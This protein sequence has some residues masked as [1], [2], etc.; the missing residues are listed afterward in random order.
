MERDDQISGLIDLGSVSQDTQGGEGKYWEG[1]AE[2]PHGGL[3]A[4]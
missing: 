1:F 3:S 2:M 4:D